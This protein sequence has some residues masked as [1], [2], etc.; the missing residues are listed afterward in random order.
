MSNIEL[1][2]WS[3]PVLLAL[4]FLRMPIGLS[5]LIVGVIGSFLITH[6]WNPGLALFKSLTYST[7]SSFSFET[8]ALLRDGEVWR[9]IVNASASVLLGL[10]AVWMGIRVAQLF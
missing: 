7:F 1:G 9:G 3:F 6:T 4:I 8:Y 10:V 2:L 5:M